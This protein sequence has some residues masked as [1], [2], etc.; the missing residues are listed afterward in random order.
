[1]DTL[2]SLLELHRDMQRGRLFLHIGDLLVERLAGYIEGYRACLREHGLSDEGYARFREWLRGTK[3]EEPI[4]EATAAYLSLAGSDHEQ[5]IARYLTRVHEFHVTQRSE[6]ALLQDISPA[7][8]PRTDAEPAAGRDALSYLLKIRE[9]L[10]RGHLEEHLGAVNA[11]RFNTF[12]DGYNACASNNHFKNELYANF[13]NWLRDVKG[14]FPGEGWP[15]KYLRDCD[16]DH[17]QAILRYLNFV[18]EFIHAHRL[19]RFRAMAQEYHQLARARSRLSAERLASFGQLC[20]RGRELVDLRLEA[21]SLSLK[22]WR[23]RMGSSAPTFDLFEALGIWGKENRYSDMIAWLCTLSS[24][25]GAAFARSLLSRMKPRLFQPSESETLLRARRE[26]V[27][28]DGRIDLVLEFE[29]LVVA[30]EVKVWS[31]EHDTPGAQPQTV[32]YP[33]AL[34]RKLQLAGLSQSVASALLS[35]AGTP[36]LGKNA[37][38]LSFF[39]LAAAV[40]DTLEQNVSPDERSVLRLFA[41]H[42]LDIASYEL[43][44]RSFREIGEALT[45]PRREWPQWVVSKAHVLEQLAAALEEC[46]S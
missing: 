19:E 37:A 23:D 32:S 3:S 30:V 35:P 17:Q 39:D 12:I 8:P 14:E 36:P 41:A 10:F 25:R 6:Q 43:T 7:L 4:E 1:M 33:R 16:G 20:M 22:H 26:Q 9:D 18:S 44:E 2:Q 11:E 40:L 21:L 31:S 29:R 38:R 28:D 24:G 34:E 27:T 13:G 5:A 42:V 15:A 46:N 45:R